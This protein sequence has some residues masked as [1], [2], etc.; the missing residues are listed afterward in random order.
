[1]AHDIYDDHEQ[2]ERVRKW[3]SENSSSIV[4]GLIAA[5]GAA[6]GWQKYQAFNAEQVVQ[7][8]Q[9]YTAFETSINADQL[10]AAEAKLGQLKEHYSEN[11][12]ND[13]AMLRLAAKMIEEGNLDRATSLLSELRSSQHT[14]IADVASLRLARLYIARDQAQQALDALSSVNKT[15]EIE[16]ALEEIRG[17]ALMRL[18][19]SDDARN[20]Y[21]AAVAATGGTPRQALDMKLEKLK[22]ADMPTTMDQAS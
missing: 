14:G 21:E 8:A 5:F 15:P 4:I 18:G 12:F 1:M 16:A 22:A 7:A 13:L 6:Y 19:R 10:E 3:L 9:T 11:L 2:G 20:A 17:D